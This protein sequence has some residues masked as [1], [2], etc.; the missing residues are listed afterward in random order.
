MTPERE[1]EL[2]AELDK[3]TGAVNPAID[4]RKQ[5]MDDHMAEYAKFQLGDEIYERETGCKLGVVT[6]LYR[7]WDS[8]ND[9]RYD[10][11]M[12]IEY[13]FKTLDGFFDNTSR[14][15]G[16]TNW[17]FA[18]KEEIKQHFEEKARALA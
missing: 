13:R 14:R 12:T 1:K 2:K 7:Y 11:S 5:W 9:P 6:E 3:L 10:T 8:Q 17:T 4:T 15:G 18:T 16:Y